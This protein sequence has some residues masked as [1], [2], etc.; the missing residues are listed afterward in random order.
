M[1]NIFEPLILAAGSHQA[2]SG[3][4][5]AMNV[6]S[7]ENGDVKITDFPACSDRMLARM[8]QNVNDRLAGDN[9]LLSAEDSL[10]ALELGHMTVGTS[11]HGLSDLDLRR[12]YVRIACMIARRVVHLDKSGTALPCIEAAERWADSPTDANLASLRTAR[13]AAAAAAADA[14]AAAA[15]AAYAAAADAA[16]DA[17]YAAYAAYAAA[18]AAAADAAAYAAAAADAAAYADAARRDFLISA[19]R[20]AITMFHDL[21]GTAP[22]PV[23][24]EVTAE[25]YAKMVAVRA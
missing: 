5:C 15:Y 4:G 13:A 19:T 23:Q 18:A 9:G 17:A 16:A 1:N 20:D 10:I 22:K 2:G 14:A 21:T 3:K 24:Q 6:I 8:V 25:A 11:S 12:V 7:W